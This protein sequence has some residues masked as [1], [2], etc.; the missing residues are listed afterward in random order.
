MYEADEL[1]RHVAVI[2]NGTIVASGT[3]AAMKARVADRTII[4]IE[5]SGLRSS[6]LEQLRALPDVASVATEERGQA[7]LVVV[8]SR[9][10]AEIVQRLLRE[11]D[12]TTLGRVVTREPTLEDAYIDLVQG[13]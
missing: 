6:I 5:T 4:E 7:E 1:C 2:A 3:P 10:G 12:S 9:V 8:Q 11:L 13:L